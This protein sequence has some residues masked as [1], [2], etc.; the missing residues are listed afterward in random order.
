MESALRTSLMSLIVLFQHSVRN[1]LESPR[2]V[3]KQETAFIHTEFGTSVLLDRF[4]PE[5]AQDDS[6]I[7]RPRHNAR[8]ADGTEDFDQMETDS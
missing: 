2:T 8:Q 7:A 1:D 6:I 3:V 5:Y 4:R